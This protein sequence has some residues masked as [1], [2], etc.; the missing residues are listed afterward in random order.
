MVKIKYTVDNSGYAT[1]DNMLFSPE[2]VK[3]FG[4]FLAMM[5]GETEYFLEEESDL[6]SFGAKID[7]SLYEDVEKLDEANN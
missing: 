2:G 4:A 7:L 3:Q 6:G 1:I 5:Q